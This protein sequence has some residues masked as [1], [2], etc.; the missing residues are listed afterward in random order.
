[1]TEIKAA[2]IGCGGRGREH[3][4]GYAASDRTKIVAVVDPLEEAARVVADK[5]GVESVYSYH[6]EMLAAHQPDIVSICTWTGLH[7][8]MVLDVAAA[9]VKA[10]H[11]EKPMAPT[12]GE[13][14]RMH[15]ACEE[16]GVQLTFC[17]QRRF[18]AQ[19]VKARDLIRRRA[20]ASC[21][22]VPPRRV[23]VPDTPRD[24]RKEAAPPAL[25]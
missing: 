23:R 16:A 19:F 21:G 8:Q 11:C 6:P 2:I 20:A 18:A 17:H 14:R 22:A 4:K 10:I 1:M 12:W 3:A 13:A 5:Y 25:R 15:R 24:A 7:A 9:G